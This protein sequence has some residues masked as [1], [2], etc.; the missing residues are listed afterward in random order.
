L[1]V[2]I[3]FATIL[4]MTLGIAGPQWGE[5]DAPATAEGRDIA[6]VLDVSRSMQAQDALGKSS[7]NRLGL[8]KDAVLDLV[9]DLSRHGGH[10]VALVVFTGDSHV[11]CP[12]TNDYDHFR[13]ALQAA[14]AESYPAVPHVSGTRIGAALENA[15]ETLDERSRGFQDILLLSDG[16]DPVDDDE[17][18]KGI[19]AADTA[20]I[21]VHTVGI[22][23]PDIYTAV[24]DEVGP[25][26]HDGIAVKTRLHEDRLELIARETGG[27]YVPA[28]TA[29]VALGDVYRKLIETRPRRSPEDVALPVYAR[30]SEW[31]F[32]AAAALFALQLLLGNSVTRANSRIQT[33]PGATLDQAA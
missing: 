3:T 22:G 13:E 33:L 2:V 27:V 19:V 21:P 5:L 9:H 32:A 1:L 29:P 15:V 25:F 7:P 10:R 30:H 31:F 6:V 20:G 12:L 23:N 8:A 24:P 4:L 16:D 17:W 11:A 18:R 14:H 26:T 28:R